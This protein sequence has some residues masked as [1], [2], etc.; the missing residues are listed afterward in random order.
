MLLIAASADRRTSGLGSA[1]SDRTS[2]SRGALRAR[3]TFFRS[4]TSSSFKPSDNAN[5]LRRRVA[6]RVFR[7]RGWIVL[8]SAVRATLEEQTPQASLTVPEHP[9]EAM[10]HATHILLVVVTVAALVLWLSAGPVPKLLFI[11][12]VLASVVLGLRASVAQIR[13][14]RRWVRS[15]WMKWKSVV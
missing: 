2:L 5:N 7:E 3:A 8:S 11:A 6:A 14:E 4:L 15:L 12:V 9:G 13:M 1:T 10:R